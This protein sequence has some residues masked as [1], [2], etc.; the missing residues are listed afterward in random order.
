MLNKIK[1]ILYTEMPVA[2]EI[3]TNETYQILT[4]IEGDEN[5]WY[6]R[7]ESGFR[8]PYTVMFNIRGIDEEILQV[9]TEAYRNVPGLLDTFTD[10]RTEIGFP[11]DEDEEDYES[12]SYGIFVNNAAGD[13]YITK[14]SE[15]DSR[16]DGYYTCHQEFDTEELA[17]QYITEREEQTKVFAVFFNRPAVDG[18]VRQEDCYSGNWKGSKHGYYNYVIDFPTEA[19]AQKYLDKLKSK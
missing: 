14:L 15:N 12:F 3:K 10:L 11:P 1:N 16:Q 9:V 19:E 7:F 5:S 6:V 17:K 13:C 2:I 4:E 8:I 18:F